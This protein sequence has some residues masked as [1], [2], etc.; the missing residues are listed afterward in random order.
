[1]RN[2]DLTL[3]NLLYCGKKTSVPAGCLYLISWLKRFGFSVDFRDFQLA[4]SKN[5]F[6]KRN[7][8]SSLQNTSDII[9]VSCMSSALPAAIWTCKQ[10]KKDNPKKII[11]LGG[12]GP[13][14]V[15]RE[16]IENFSFVD[17]VVIGP[18]EHT[19]VE[20]MEALKTG[21]PI[22]QIEGIACR[23]DNNVIL[24][25]SREAPSR[26]DSI[27]TD[28]GA[29]NLN[30]YKEVP[31]LSGR[32]CPYNCPFCSIK[33]LYPVY[34]HRDI[35]DIEREIDYVLRYKNSPTLIVLQDEGFLVN[36]ERFLKLCQMIKRK[37]KRKDITLSCYGRIDLMDRGNMFALADSGFSLIFFGVESGSDRILRFINKG[38]TVRMA[39]EVLLK[40]RKYVSNISASF[41]WGFPFEEMSDFIETCLFMR[42]LAMK[43]ISVRLRLLG[44]IPGT[45]F[46]N[47]YRDKLKFSNHLVSVSDIAWSMTESP[48][49]KKLI[50]EHPDVFPYFFHYH[51]D[52]LDDKYKIFKR[53]YDFS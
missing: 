45:K 44:P 4:E 28:F 36:K 30:K 20:L 3:V 17:I 38:F 5:P 46:Y 53:I 35:S 2:K 14:L 51:S 34:I 9:G 43:K 27:F 23:V 26:I 48:Y 11:I 18:G 15:A 10:I 25:P 41:M 6:S 19:L 22:N 50:V 1:M 40:L 47:L 42:Y 24:T 33:S 32:G 16:I 49:A 8:L 13:S 21:K 52:N 29:I 7:I 31:V 39:Q 37:K 12:P